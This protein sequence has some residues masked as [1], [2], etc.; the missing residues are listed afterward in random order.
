MR[1]V[2]VTW[3][4]PW[5]VSGMSGR[6]RRVSILRVE[7][8]EGD[9]RVD[10]VEVGEEEGSETSLAGVLPAF[11]PFRLAVAADEDAGS[12][13]CGGGVCV[14]GRGGDGGEVGW[15]W[16]WRFVGDAA[17]WGWWDVV[18]FLGRRGGAGTGVAIGQW[19]VS[20]W[21]RAVSG[22]VRGCTG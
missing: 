3:V 8:G 12:R 17:W 9:A 6:M 20:G 11:A 7:G 16:C 2:D 1:P 22:L 15:M 21:L 18:F 19:T 5:G 13:H 14:G 10:G 4:V